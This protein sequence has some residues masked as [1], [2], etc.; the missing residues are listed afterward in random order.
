VGG[1]GFGAQ[2]RGALT[3]IDLDDVCITNINRQLPALDGTI[4]LPK[5]S[6]LARRVALINPE[7]RVTEV[8]QFIGENDAADLLSGEV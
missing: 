7:C 6:V 5:V 1:R 3:L 8:L 2:R 4:G